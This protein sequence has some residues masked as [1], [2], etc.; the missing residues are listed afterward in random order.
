MDDLTNKSLGQEIRGELA[1]DDDDGPWPLCGGPTLAGGRADHHVVWLKH[2]LTTPGQWD[3][4][5][6]IA[7]ERRQQRGGIGL[8]DRVPGLRQ[9]LAQPWPQLLE[10]GEHGPRDVAIGLAA[11]LELL[12]VE[13]VADEVGMGLEPGGIGRIAAMSLG[14]DHFHL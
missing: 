12:H 3:R 11:D 4:R 5:P 7:L 9:I 2:R 13:F 14:E 6:A 8:G 1:G 10:I